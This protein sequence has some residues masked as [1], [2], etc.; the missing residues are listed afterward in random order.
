MKFIGIV[1]RNPVMMD[2]LLRGFTFHGGDVLEMSVAGKKLRF[3]FCAFGEGI[4]LRDLLLRAEE[5]RK[6]IKGSGVVCIAGASDME[7]LVS[8]ALNMGYRIYMFDLDGDFLYGRGLFPVFRIRDYG[9]L[10]QEMEKIL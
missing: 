2:A 1:L 7:K 4:P 8:S 9:Q 10:N 5:R 3:S 6:E